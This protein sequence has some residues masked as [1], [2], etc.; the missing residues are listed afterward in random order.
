MMTICLLLVFRVLEIQAKAL[1][2][3]E[4]PPPLL[5]IP[6][7]PF[8]LMAAT[9]VSMQSTSEKNLETTSIM[10]VQ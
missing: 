9:T 5:E 7:F 6:G 10:K 8:F 1:L 4:Q 3:I 2:I